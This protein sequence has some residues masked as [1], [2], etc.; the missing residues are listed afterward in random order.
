MRCLSLCVS[1]PVSVTFV[2]P[3]KTNKHIIKIFS[4]SGTPHY[5]RFPY[6]TAYQ[7]SDGNPPNEGIECRWGGQ[8]SRFWAYIWLCLLLAL[9]HGRCCQHG[10]RWTTATVRPFHKLWHIAGVDGGIRRR[11][12]YD[13][14]PQRYAKDNR[15][16]HLTARSDK[17]VAYVTN[18]KKLH[19]TFC[20]L[21]ANYW[22][23]RSIARP[24]CD[25]RATCIC[26]R[27]VHSDVTMF[28]SV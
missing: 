19:S 4:P 11:N 16:A 3:V 22:Q 8:K 15:T 26:G 24:L 14:K 9:Q 12:L 5:S 7:H 6:Q 27:C 13:K 28:L 25:S 21:E 23:T 10:R 20:T 18:N 2:H 1:V 17:S